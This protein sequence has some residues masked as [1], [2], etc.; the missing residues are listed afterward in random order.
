MN[1]LLSL[2][3]SGCEYQGTRRDTPE[4]SR[5]PAFILK[6]EVIL[7]IAAYS[8]IPSKRWYLF[9]RAHGVTI[10]TTVNLIMNI[11]SGKNVRRDRK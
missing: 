8:Y 6:V 5:L 9:I 10:Q 4:D 3:T 11:T 1:P 2:E 7:K